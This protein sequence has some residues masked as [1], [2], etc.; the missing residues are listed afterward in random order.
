M[1]SDVNSNVVEE[2]SGSS[3]SKLEL[4]EDSTPAVLKTCYVC[5]FVPLI[6]IHLMPHATVATDHS[7]PLRK[8]H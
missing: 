4:S 2:A 6:T 5:V 8:H 1:S 7:L 3:L